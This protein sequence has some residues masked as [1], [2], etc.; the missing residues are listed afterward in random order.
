[1]GSSAVGETSLALMFHDS[2]AATADTAVLPGV[3]GRRPLRRTV[4]VR[5]GTP[6]LRLQVASPS[7]RSRGSNS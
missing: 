1:M 3:L 2:P 7:S 4:Q 5:L 6:T